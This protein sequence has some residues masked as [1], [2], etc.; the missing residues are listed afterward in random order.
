M[1]TEKKV[2]T[3]VEVLSRDS[4]WVCDLFEWRTAVGLCR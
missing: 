3:G 2:V 1:I 4:T